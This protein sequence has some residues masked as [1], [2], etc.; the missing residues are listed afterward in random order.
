MGIA[1]TH[2][3]RCVCLE[4]ALIELAD[5]FPA[6]GWSHAGKPGHGIGAVTCDQR[7]HITGEDRFFPRLFDGLGAVLLARS[8]TGPA[9]ENQC[10]GKYSNSTAYS[11]LQ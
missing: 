3:S 9:N 5:R 2:I 1:K 6:L 7:V 4:E 10:T 8:E 11:N